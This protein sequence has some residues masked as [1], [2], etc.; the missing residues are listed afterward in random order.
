MWE[1]ALT[2]LDVIVAML[3][4]AS[5]AKSA[6]NGHLSTVY[7]N[8]KQLPVIADKV[9]SIADRQEKMIE[10]LVA[11]SVAESDEEA[12]VDTDRLA[13][14]LRDGES[15]RVYL[16]RDMNGQSPFADVED[17]E[18]PEEE[19]RWREHYDDD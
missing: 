14:D 18:V 2:R 7:Q 16:E 3:A 9:E 8:I 1:S 19:R 11:L 17:E 4:I 6:Y 13:A 5:A 12:T 15:Y 10:G